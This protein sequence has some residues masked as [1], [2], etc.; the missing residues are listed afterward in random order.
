MILFNSQSWCYKT[1]STLDNRFTKWPKD[2]RRQMIY[3]MAKIIWMDYENF[4]IQMGDSTQEALYHFP[5]W[6]HES[7]RQIYITIM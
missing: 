7:I 6:Y 3:L 4:V 5:N 1:G 2:I